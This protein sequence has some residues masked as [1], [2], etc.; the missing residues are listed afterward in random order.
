MSGKD[1]LQDMEL[2]VCMVLKEK[3][4]LSLKEL[5]QCIGILRETFKVEKEKETL[6]S[7]LGTI[8]GCVDDIPRAVRILTTNGRLE[9]IGKTP[10][11]WKYK[12]NDTFQV[13]DHAPEGG[14]EAIEPFLRQYCP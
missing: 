4:P 12:V 5:S 6:D 1:M 13:C 7:T 3:G 9:R 2:L 8:D 10:R 11:E 14:L